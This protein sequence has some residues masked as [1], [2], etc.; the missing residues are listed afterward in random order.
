[1]CSCDLSC[2]LLCPCS[3]ISSTSLY[4]VDQSVRVLL[5]KLHVRHVIK[6]V[7]PA[8]LL[9]V[10]YGTSVIQ[11]YITRRFNGN[12]LKLDNVAMFVNCFSLMQAECNWMLNQLTCVKVI[13]KSNLKKIFQLSSIWIGVQLCLV[14][15]CVTS[16]INFCAV[17]LYCP[18]VQVETYVTLGL[19]N[20][21]VFIRFKLK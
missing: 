12:S 5:V 14:W 3:C 20:K 15:N 16:S 13:F 11:Q 21:F 2:W 4:F 8:Y 1:M 6:N 18:N 7:S 19:I 9:H 17:L 10:Y